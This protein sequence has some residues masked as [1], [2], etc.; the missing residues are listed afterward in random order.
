MIEVDDAREI[1]LRHAR[2]LPAIPYSLR[3]GGVLAEDIV[4][5]L[6]SPP[7]AKALMDGYAVLRG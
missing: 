1:V 5:D 3:L 7:F 2:R 6:D 4:A